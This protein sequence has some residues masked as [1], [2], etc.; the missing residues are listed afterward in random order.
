MADT[1]D[2][3]R[4][5]NQALVLAYIQNVRSYEATDHVGLQNRLYGRRLRIADQMKARDV[6]LL[7]A[8]AEC[9]NPE[10]RSW[11]QSDLQE[12]PPYEP[13]PHRPLAAEWQWQCDNPPPP[14]MSR[15]EI[16]QRL[17]DA[18]PDLA[19]RLLDLALP[20]IG[21]WPQ[22]ARAD[23]AGMSRLGGMPL[24]PPGWPWP[25]VEG[26]PLL[27]VGQ[28]N[29]AELRGLPSSEQ[30]PSSG[31]LAFFGDHD[32]VMACRI[33]AGDI[34]VHHWP[35]VDRLVPAM[36]P[37]EPAFVFPACALAFRPLIDL[38][39]PFSCVA[40]NL[41]R[42]RKLTSRYADACKAIRRHGIPSDLDYY[43]S[44]SKL[45]GWPALVQQHD[46]DELASAHRSPMRLLLQVD[47]YSNGERLHGWGPGGSLYFL[48]PE[49]SLRMRR[50]DGCVFEIQFT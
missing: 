13:P 41:L 48:L 16:A 14:A 2:L 37:I 12:R 34:A 29:C 21:L 31:L 32:A 10:L 38:P 9:S 39:D 49:N 5:S 28:I 25:T 45:L 11:A 4:L 40:Q 19:D 26:E 46:L 42:D 22:R 20:A 33:E 1:D 43:C 17:H 23:R 24:S 50:F 3:A 8:L 15:V 18:L 44:F 30:L 36:P 35:D 6:A 27:F 47:D 7:Q